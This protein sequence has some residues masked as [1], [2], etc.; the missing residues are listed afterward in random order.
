MDF[1]NIDS[2]YEMMS[3]LKGVGSRAASTLP[4]P[5]E[6]F[7]ENGKIV[8]RP[9]VPQKDPCVTTILGKAM[10]TGKAASVTAL[11]NKARAIAE[12]LNLV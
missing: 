3:R 6:Y 12:F 1:S 7:M 10:P 4:E 5:R 2:V 8:S 11:E 9:I